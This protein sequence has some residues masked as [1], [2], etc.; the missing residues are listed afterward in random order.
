EGLVT[1]SVY[2]PT[3]PK[4]TDVAAEAIGNGNMRITWVDNATTETNYLVERRPYGGTDW[5][6]ESWE[7]IADL[8]AN[9]TEYVDSTGICDTAYFYRVKVY[10]SVGDVSRTSDYTSHIEVNCLPPTLDIC[11]IEEYPVN[12][13]PPE[14]YQERTFFSGTTQLSGEGNILAIQRGIPNDTGRITGTEIH[15]YDTFTGNRL[16]EIYD[17]ILHDIDYFGEYL[18]FESSRNFGPSTNDF[19]NED[20]NRELFL[21]DLQDAPSI[22]AEQITS[23]I[24]PDVAYDNVRIGGGGEQVVFTATGAV[25]GDN[26]SFHYY[27][28][29]NNALGEVV[30]KLVPQSFAVPMSEMGI[31]V[32]AYADNIVYVADGNIFLYVQGAVV[33]Q[34]TNL[35]DATG[36]PL[37]L[38]PGSLHISDFERR[39]VFAA[40]NNFTGQNPDYGAELYTWTQHYGLSQLT[41]TLSDSISPA[42]V[43]IDGQRTLLTDTMNLGGL[44][45]D[46]GTEYFFSDLAGGIQ[47]ITD[48]AIFG[49]LLGGD[50][51]VNGEV[52]AFIMPGEPI[53]EALAQS[54]PDRYLYPNMRLFLGTCEQ[55][56]RFPELVTP[57]DLT[58]YQIG[59]EIH[60]AW[61]EDQ[62]ESTNVVVE[63]STDD[64]TIWEQIAIAPSNSIFV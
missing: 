30:E 5:S 8:P 58:A 52:I 3:P 39:V 28:R 63:R 13:P 14:P 43:S 55:P 61:F 26:N 48:N 23:S 50:M 59:T 1:I 51:S 35:Q 33:G 25:S 37:D 56:E 46:E 15:I 18:V 64:G 2:Y 42:A 20:G 62:L 49:P 27:Y 24:N 17:A 34:M 38:V 57:V 4:P 16:M 60:L 22:R 21:L 53:D 12:F 47:Q 40:R 11:T 54:D 45:E 7:Q 44:N 9:S 41:N 19:D 32:D 29:W 6:E 31:A 10:D 36:Q